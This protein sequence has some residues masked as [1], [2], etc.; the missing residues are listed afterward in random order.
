MGS[1]QFHKHPKGRPSK[2]RKPLSKVHQNMQLCMSQ[3]NEQSN[4]EEA[5]DYLETLQNDTGN[6]LK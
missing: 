2:D 1:E 4:E 5:T 3:G 6:F